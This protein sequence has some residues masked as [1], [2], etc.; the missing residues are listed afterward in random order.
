[1]KNTIT[2]NVGIWL[3][4]FVILMSVCSL[5]GCGVKNFDDMDRFL[6]G[7]EKPNYEEEPH[8]SEFPTQEQPTYDPVKGWGSF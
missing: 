8:D 7:P 2:P 3:L 5:A 4:S 6:S 1:M